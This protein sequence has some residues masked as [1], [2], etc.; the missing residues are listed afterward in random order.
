MIHLRYTALIVRAPEPVGLAL[1]CVC[2]DS[3]LLNLLLILP[4]IKSVLERKD[5]WSEVVLPTFFYRQ[6]RDCGMKM[7]REIGAKCFQRLDGLALI[8]SQISYFIPMT[9]K[10]HDLDDVNLWSSSNASYSDFLLFSSLLLLWHEF[11]IL[12]P[13]LRVIRNIGRKSQELYCQQLSS[14]MVPELG[15]SKGPKQ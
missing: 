3:A 6:A 8:E 15:E 7:S 12:N 4:L 9:G 13:W 5:S 2:S 1:L 11:A 14:E 10:P